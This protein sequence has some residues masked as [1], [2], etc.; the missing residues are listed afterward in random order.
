MPGALGLLRPH[1]THER[2]KAPAAA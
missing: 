1:G 2:R